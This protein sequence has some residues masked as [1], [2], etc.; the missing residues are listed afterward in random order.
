MA[1][2]PDVREGRP[3]FKRIR[4]TDGRPARL[5]C[6]GNRSERQKPKTV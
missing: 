5:S 6:S 4:S 2:G 3:V 1:E